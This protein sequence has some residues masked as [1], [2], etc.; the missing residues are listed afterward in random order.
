VRS[1]ALK[2]DE[3]CQLHTTVHAKSTISFPFEDLRDPVHNGYSL[4]PFTGGI[5]LAKWVDFRQIGAEPL[6]VGRA[7]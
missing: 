5:M 7:R 6:S 3:D 4:F 1:A 2:G